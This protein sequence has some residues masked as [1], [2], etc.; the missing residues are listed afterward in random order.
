MSGGLLSS[1][2]ILA[3]CLLPSG[4]LNETRERYDNANKVQQ[5]RDLHRCVRFVTV[6][7]DGVNVNEGSHYVD[8][9][10][11]LISVVEQGSVSSREKFP[12]YLN[13]PGQELPDRCLLDLT[14]RRGISSL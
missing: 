11:Q 6:L 8:D 14:P 13:E 2:D 10:I 12:D 1:L 4:G 7:N 9:V 5:E 3:R